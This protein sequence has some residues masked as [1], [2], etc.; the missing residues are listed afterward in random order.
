M[1]QTAELLPLNVTDNPFPGLR[2]FE[3]DEYE[4][5]FG[6]DGQ[7]DEVLSKLRKSHFVAVIGTSGS[8]KSSLVRAGVLPA[9]Y[10]GHLTIAGSRWRVALF[11]PGNNPIGNLAAALD[12]PDVLGGAASNAP[13][14]QRSV[15]TLLRST[16]LGLLEAVRQAQLPPNENLLILADQFEELF[17][18]KDATQSSNRVGDE[19]AAFVKLLLEATRQRELPIYLV[20]TMRSDYLGEAAQFYGL[21]EAINEGQYLI[22]RLTEDGWREAITGPIT[23]NSAAIT[24]PLVNRLLNDAGNDP[25]QLPILQHALMRTWE[26]WLHKRPGHHLAHPA[27]Q[28]G[29]AL[30][31][32]CYETVGGFANALSNHADE[33][34]DEL[35]PALQP[36]AEKIFKCL[37][38]KTRDN[39]EGRRPA[40][41]RELCAVTGATEA[42]VKTVVET[43]RQ[44]GRSFLMPPASESLKPGTLI[45]ISHESLMRGWQ[46]LRKWVEEEAEAA[47]VLKRLSENAALHAQGQQDFYYHPALQI[48]LDWRE[49]QQP[50]AAWAAHYGC[51][52]AQAMKY[53]DD[54]QANNAREEAELAAQ[55]AR[56]L[57][58]AQTLAAERQRRVR[59]LRISL[60]VLTLLLLALAGLTGY[61][62]QQK[63][64]AQSERA[65]AQRQRAE[66]VRLREVAEG[67]LT[68]VRVSEKQAQE[69]KE[70]ALKAEDK[71]QQEKQRAELALLAT[72]KAEASAVQAKKLAQHAEAVAKDERDK[73]EAAL[74]ESSAQKLRAETALGT[75]NEIDR[76]AP[77]FHTI[78]RDNYVS[79]LNSVAYSPSGETILTGSASGVLWLNRHDGQRTLYRRVG[80]APDAALP[81]AVTDPQSA[82]HNPNA[83]SVVAF[84]HQSASGAPVNFLAAH[85][86]GAVE[87][88]RLADEQSATLEQAALVKLAAL[89]GD[90]TAVNFAAFSLDDS[91]VVTAGADRR[92]RV[93]G[94]TSGKPVAVL[95]PHQ[96]VVN[97]V[98]F[99]PNGKLLAT[100]SDDGTAQIWSLV[101]YYRIALLRP[102]LEK[103]NRVN[104]S[105]DGKYL[106]TAGAESVARVWNVQTGENVLQ[107][108]GKTGHTAELNS[109]VFSPDGSQIVTASKDRTARLWPVREALRS[110][111]RRNN[112]SPLPGMVEVNGVLVPSGEAAA[113]ALAQTV[114]LPEVQSLVLEGHD[115]D[116]TNASF[117]PDGKWVFTISQDRTARV[118][119]AL[120]VGGRKAGEV[121]AVLRGHI[122][123]VTS[124]DFNA[125]DKHLVTASTDRTVRVWDLAALGDLRINAEVQVDNEKYGG[126]CPVTFK[127][128]GRVRVE[129]GAGAVKYQ[130]ITSEGE[131]GRPQTL[132]FDAPG[133]KEISET[134]SFNRSAPNAWLAFKILEPTQLESAHVPVSVRCTNYERAT[135]SAPPPAEA[136]TVEVLQQI[137][138][139]ASKDRLALYLP[140]LQQSFTEFKINT[141]A[142][143]AAF[144]AQLAH[145]SGE[146]RYMEEP[147]G[148]TASQLRYEPPSDLAT[149]LGNTQPGDGQ[150]F[151]GRG[152]FQ[153]VGRA[154]YQKYGQA[155]GLDLLGQ[156]DL[157]ATSAVVFRTAGY[158]WQSQGLNELAEQQ[159]FPQI[160]RRINGG[161]NG[162]AERTRYYNIAKQ[163]LGV[164]DRADQKQAK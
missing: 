60:G 119:Q 30:D 13:F 38:E 148:P 82:Q 75:V 112:P 99:S 73:A 117:S 86:T 129:G 142:R 96:G 71:A 160:T 59:W 6:R 143:Q 104:F 24:P 48:A 7:S 84:G 145:E 87:V 25:N 155:L 107:L 163:V 70:A 136:L 17:R 34:Y 33:A 138:P 98:A 134:W 14:A 90:N 100:A 151:K 8:G 61:A 141:P 147:W 35:P 40:T 10:S 53:L 152:P 57:E 150:R 122:G 95:P 42:D 29:A 103:I 110:R 12:Q 127:I 97:H 16:S 44:E 83:I 146:L 101:P 123:P 27:F 79:A 85:R 115:A 20:L 55:R 36:L 105:P 65:D 135:T 88:W 124:L 64:Q 56:E 153:I 15:E 67:S 106:V 130:F 39:R 41:I 132:N 11:R 18:L 102:G 69:E 139:R 114:E 3:T 111:E 120:T 121:L 91:L 37:T 118:W 116:V 156:P 133:V 49:R 26:E 52:F 162:L 1:S 125:R 62:F 92:V 19:A 77:Y 109:A 81:P 31:L 94:L 72:R 9:L 63:A 32:C 76:S 51:D 131:L 47:L 137:M 43:F 23:V 89:P 149:R 113:D 161:L 2:P 164:S 50:N 58:A 159:D 154:N 140:Y 68:K 157:A 128:A 158:F 46:R 78:F 4:L 66:A 54:S 74:K 108:G 21:P 93:W 126:N 45:D 144:L 80:A 22:P 28:R 5:F